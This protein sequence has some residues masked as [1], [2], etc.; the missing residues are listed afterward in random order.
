VAERLGKVAQELSADRVD[1][2]REKADV[3]DPSRLTSAA[4]CRSDRTAKSPIGVVLIRELLRAV[5]G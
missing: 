3:I 2:F 4:L 1:L 5:D